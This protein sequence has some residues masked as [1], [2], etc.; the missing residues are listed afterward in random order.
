MLFLFMSMISSIPYRVFVRVEQKFPSGFSMKKVGASLFNIFGTMFDGQSHPLTI[1]LMSSENGRVVSQFVSYSTDGAIS[2]IMRYKV[3][4][5]GKTE[6]GFDTEV[7][8]KG[9][10]EVIYELNDVEPR[11]IRLNFD[12][13]HDVCALNFVPS[14]FRDD[15]ELEV[16]VQ[17]QCAEI[18]TTNGKDVAEEQ[19]SE[20]YQVDMEYYKI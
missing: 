6:Q 15:D 18:E 4:F 5:S 13:P 1:S 2:S 9:P 20:I 10:A 3:T 17:V 16:H 7:K 14:R 8:V 12:Y 11:T 19:L